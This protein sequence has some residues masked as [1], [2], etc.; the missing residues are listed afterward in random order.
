VNHALILKWFDEIKQEFSKTNL[1]LLEKIY[2]GPP[3]LSENQE[4]Y[5]TQTSQLFD[6]WKNNIERKLKFEVLIEDGLYE[7]EDEVKQ[8]RYSLSILPH[9]FNL[10]LFHSSSIDL[11]PSIGQLGVKIS[12][13]R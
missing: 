1:T 10:F 4:S 12:L 3:Y 6:W 8:Q 9:D 2:G 11:I 7:G 13:S 5:W